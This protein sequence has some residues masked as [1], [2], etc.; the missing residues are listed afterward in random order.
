MEYFLKPFKIAFLTLLT[1]LVGMSGLGFCSA[2]CL[3]SVQE[4]HKENQLV[5]PHCP[6]DQT[7]SPS[8]PVNHEESQNDCSCQHSFNTAF[9]KNPHFSGVL[10][11]NMGLKSVK[12]IDAYQID[13]LPT[14]PFQK[15][16]KENRALGPPGSLLES[17]LS[18]LSHT[19]HPPP[20]LA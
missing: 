19:N 13:N 8:T 10:S 18:F 9:L 16:V 1:V 11:L 3:S 4:C 6:S 7:A 14:P 2:S 15:Q 20:D 12:L 17:L 5:E